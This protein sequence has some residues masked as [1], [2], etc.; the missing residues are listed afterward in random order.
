[1]APGA[2]EV[3]ETAHIDEWNIL[4]PAPSDL[5]HRA[6][7]HLD[8]VGPELLVQ[9]TPR[10]LGI[11]ETVAGEDRAEMHRG[12][13]SPDADRIGQR[14]EREALHRLAQARHQELIQGVT[15]RPVAA[16][17]RPAAGLDGVETVLPLRAVVVLGVAGAD[18]DVADA[19]GRI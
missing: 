11:D 4:A 7:L 2:G 16:Q 5:R 12:P 17:R 14:L 13:P 15:G 9:E 8:G 1:M 6:T 10:A 3:A 18:H 19:Q